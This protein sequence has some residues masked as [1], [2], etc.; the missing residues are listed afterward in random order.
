MVLIGYIW[1]MRFII[2]LLALVLAGCASTQAQKQLNYIRANVDETGK[3]ADICRAEVDLTETAQKM[4]QKIGV[5]SLDQDNRFD[6]L[7][8]KDKL[9]EE[10]KPVV[11]S[12]L[13]LSTK[14]NN[15]IKEGHSKSHPLFLIVALEHL[16]ALDENYIKLLEN[17]ITIGE[18]NKKAEL[19]F[20]QTEKKWVEAGMKIDSNLAESHNREIEQEIKAYDNRKRSVYTYCNKLGNAVV[21]NSY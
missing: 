2:I 19:N 16:K 1:Y 7:R 5:H 15:I 8:S 14:C 3:K 4:R 12:F 21:C 18:F 9:S 20:S 17:E 13:K 6:L 11:V 10:L